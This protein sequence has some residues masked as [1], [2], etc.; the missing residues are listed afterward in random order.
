L[1]WFLGGLGVLALL[2]VDLAGSALEVRWP[3][4]LRWAGYVVGCLLVLNSRMALDV[5]FIYFQF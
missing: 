2:V 5:S 3:A 1:T 4:T